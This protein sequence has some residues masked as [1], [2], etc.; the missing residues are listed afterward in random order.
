MTRM[1][2]TSRLSMF[3]EPAGSRSSCRRLGRRYME[4]CPGAVS[5]NGCR[6]SA[7]P[8]WPRHARPL[9]R[10]RPSAERHISGAQCG[11]RRAH[12]AEQDARRRTAA[13]SRV[14]GTRNRATRTCRAPRC[15]YTAPVRGCI[16]GGSYDARSLPLRDRSRPHRRR[17]RGCRG[18]VVCGRGTW[19]VAADGV[20]V[21]RAAGRRR[22]AADRGERTGSR[23]SCL[24]AAGTCS[25][26]RPGRSSCAAGF[27]ESVRPGVRRSGNISS[28][29]S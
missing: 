8:T 9:G 19:L 3:R 27:R 2:V 5:P 10:E 15:P 12:R 11:E 20:A 29:I 16:S 1:I 6:S 17:A 25:C 7:R 13:C 4:L 14:H 26:S 24:A 18:R 28:T 21:R 22:A 23:R